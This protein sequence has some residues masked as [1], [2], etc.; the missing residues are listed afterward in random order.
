MSD[1][2]KIFGFLFIIFVY[3]QL[4][5]NQIKVYRMSDEEYIEYKKSFQEASPFKFTHKIKKP[6]KKLQLLL[7]YLSG[8][9]FFVLIF[10][11]FNAE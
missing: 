8:A 3:S 2:I 7:I 5:R 10:L 9:F 11:M 6:N 4:F 1:I